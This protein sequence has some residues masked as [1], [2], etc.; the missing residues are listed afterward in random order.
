MRININIKLILVFLIF[1]SFS[2]ENSS[3]KVPV[4]SNALNIH[5]NEIDA[6]HFRNQ[7]NK[8]F[9][10][11]SLK[12][13]VHLVNFF[14]TTCKTICP[15]MEIPINDLAENNP[16][17]KFISFTIDPENDSISVLREY[18]DRKK[19]TNRAFLRGTQTALSEIAKY[20]LSSISDEDDEVIYHTSYVVLLDNKMRIR[21]L[22]NSLD[23]DDLA[24]LKK[25]IP[26]LLKE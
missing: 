9:D 3:K 17:V 4:I 10:F 18:Y 20:Y 2:C 16:D 21:G 11:S 25:D 26:I 23:K 14:F 5:K 1:I 12:G 22:Y 7:F 24:F 13:N 19:N 8:D 15:M 6:F